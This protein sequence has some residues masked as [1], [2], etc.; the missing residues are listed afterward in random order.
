[1]A[2]PQHTSSLTSL[3]ERALLLARLR[4]LLFA[5]VPGSSRTLPF[6]IQPTGEEAQGFLGARKAYVLSELLVGEP[7][8]LLINST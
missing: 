8:T 1:M 7:E 3:E 6:L 4:T 5:A 2:Q